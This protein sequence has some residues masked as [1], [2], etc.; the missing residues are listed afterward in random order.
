MQLLEQDHETVLNNL[1]DK[2][3]AR[4]DVLPPIHALAHEN[5]LCRICGHMN[6]KVARIHTKLLATRSFLLMLQQHDTQELITLYKSNVIP[7]DIAVDLAP[8]FL[9]LRS[10]AIPDGVA[11]KISRLTIAI[12]TM[13]STIKGLPSP[14]W[15]ADFSL[16]LRALIQE[17]GMNLI[18]GTNYCQP[19]EIEISFSQALLDETLLLV[20]DIHVLLELPR[21]NFARQLFQLIERILSERV[22]ELN[23][24]HEQVL[25]QFVFFR[26]FFDICYAARRDLWMP[27]PPELIQKVARA[28]REPAVVFRLPPWLKMRQPGGTE[29][30]ADYVNSDPGF[31]AAAQALTAAS[32]MPNP[33]DAL[34]YVYVALAEIRNRCALDISQDFIS[35]DDTFILLVVVFLASDLVDVFALQRFVT[36]LGPAHLSSAWGYAKTMLEALAMHCCQMEEVT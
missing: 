19:R 27:S 31:R 35:F 16:F 10:P 15:V 26:N 28:S 24:R 36:E 9:R 11:E 3:P 8:R 5:M 33:F 17:I 13:T 23:G 1:E 14:I 25:A 18:E 6:L 21:D 34:Y 29:A 32:F 20:P 4:I 22:N 7:N 12:D 30:I 2:Q